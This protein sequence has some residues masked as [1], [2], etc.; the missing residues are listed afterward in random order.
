VSIFLKITFVLFL[1]VA[2]VLPAGCSPTPT[3]EEPL[4]KAVIVDQ[5]S[6]RDPNPEF[7][8]AAT[9]IL[10]SFGFTVDVWQG[11]DITVDFYHKL[12][13]MGYRFVLLRVHSGTLVSQEGD[14]V[15]VSNTTYLFTT[16]NY[17]TTKYVGDQL[18]DRVSN[19]LMEEN[20]PLVFA[21][22]SEFMRRADGQFNGSF[23]LAMGC[24][25]FKYND[26]PAAFLEKGAAV[27]IGWSDVVTLEYVDRATLDLLNN[28]FTANM[29]LSE[30]I[31]TTLNRLG[32]DPYFGSHLK[33]APSASANR[34]MVDI[35]GQLSNEK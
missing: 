10:E 26:M 12:P 11:L 24:E 4:N 27:Y 18:A 28:L 17:T 16:E 22:N 9:E 30:G 25:S 33:C 35:L 19:A 14:A 34:T 32:Y 5:L 6:L 7:I 21:V 8:V 1:L 31:T 29:T 15:T 13:S 20:T 23:I 3:V 2:L